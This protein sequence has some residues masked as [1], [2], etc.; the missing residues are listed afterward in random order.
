[1][2]TIFDALCANRQRVA[3]TTAEQRVA[4]LQR[5]LDSL[6]RHRQEVRDALFADFRRHPSE[7][8]LTEIYPVTGEIKHAMRHLKSWMRPQ[9]VPTPAAMTGSRSWIQWQPKGVALILS[10]WNFPVNLTLGPLVS[11]VASGNVVMLKPSEHT[12]HASATLK[13]ILRDVFDPQEVALVE[14]DAEVAQAVL[15]LPFHHIFFTGSPAV[16]KMVMKAAAEHLASVTL[17]LGGKSPTIVDAGADLRAAARRIA[18]AKWMNNGQI[19]IA[20]DYVFAHESCHDELTVRLGQAVKDFYGS[21]PQRSASYGRIVNR[22]QFDRIASYLDG[23]PSHKTAASGAGP[24]GA[25]DA[26]DL[27]VQPT[28]LTGVETTDKIMREEIFGPILPIL[29]YSSIDEPL[30]HIAAGE[31]PLALYLYTR[32]QKTVDYVLR[33]SRAGGTCINHNGLQFFNNDLPFGGDNFSGIGKSHG[34]YGFQAFSNARAVVEQRSKYSPIE[35]MMPPYGGRLKQA[36]ID[37]TIRWL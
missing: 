2:D 32:D 5:L 31:K 16:G 1:M 34:V 28:V 9:R 13:S 37:F 23:P 36:L 15:K 27:Y 8:D 20:P 3:D 33:H 4:K 17:E 29:R 19:C 25:L 10:P 18:W 6:L 22:R 24:S 14:G 11:A 30:R 7:V 21:Q 26:A 12:P 35:L